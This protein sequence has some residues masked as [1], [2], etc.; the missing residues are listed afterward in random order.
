M[1]EEMKPRYLAPGP[2]RVEV[3]ATVMEMAKD[4]GPEVFVAQSRAL[5]RRPDQQKVLRGIRVP[6]LVLCG[7]HDELCPVKRHELMAG[8]I[9]GAEL[10]VIDDAGHLPTL[11]QP[12]EVTAVLRAWLESPLVL[13]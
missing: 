10:R 2:G 4:L 13:R 3:M 6:A 1:R 5:Q 11:E 7:A 12:A 8:L 9:P